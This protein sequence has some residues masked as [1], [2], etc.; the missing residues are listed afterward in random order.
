MTATLAALAVSGA[1]LQPSG[2]LFSSP[3]LCNV[4]RHTTTPS[5]LEVD[6]F[7]TPIPAALDEDAAA[8]LEEVEGDVEKA[9]KSFIGYT[10]AYVAEE[11]PE[12][13]KKIQTDSDDPEAHAA[14]VEVTW[15]AI[16]A[17]MPMTHSSRP[18]VEAARR[19]TAI[20]RTALPADGA[21]ETTSV[22][23]VGCGNGLLLPFLREVGLP[24]SNYRGVDL[25]S[26]MIDLARHAHGA[27]GAVFEDL[28]FD[29]EVARDAK[30]ETIVFNGCLQFFDDQPATLLEA[31][32]LLSNSSDARIIV[33]HISGASFVRRELGD[34]PKTVRNTM[35]FLEMM[36]TIAAQADMQVVLPSFL[37]TEV[38]EIET[39]LERFY[40][41]VFR[42]KN[43]DDETNDGEAPATLELPDAM[44]DTSLRL[45]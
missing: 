18:T 22:L 16:A 14:L 15:D 12:L 38:D 20:A 7:D 2:Y 44:V 25:S 23:D 11:M 42:R 30:Y 21:V 10:L 4:V 35:P 26:R 43:A 6:M 3:R 1:L 39:A 41:V 33:S 31:A 8:L 40:L 45:N 27:S 37:G 29:Q 34:N 9:Q 24:S 19:L 13:Y 32:R 5:M 17:F 28:S 36:Q